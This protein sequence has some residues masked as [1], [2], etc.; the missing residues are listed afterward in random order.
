MEVR[1]FGNNKMGRHLS[2]EV[3]WVYAGFDSQKLINQNI[4]EAA[5]KI[6]L[7]DIVCRGGIEYILKCRHCLEIFWSSFSSFL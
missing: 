4:I 5:G 1:Q 2:T 6:G 7:T 3:E